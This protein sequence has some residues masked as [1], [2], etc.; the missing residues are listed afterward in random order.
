MSEKFTLPESSRILEQI[1]AKKAITS[2]STQ[3]RHKKVHL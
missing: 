2:D 1:S 3:I